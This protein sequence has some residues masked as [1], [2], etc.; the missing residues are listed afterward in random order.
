MMGVVA[1]EDGKNL[2][3]YAHNKRLL[4][5]GANIMLFNFRNYVLISMHGVSHLYPYSLQRKM[6]SPASLSFL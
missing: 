2:G 5:G 1:L 6:I 3:I 4:V